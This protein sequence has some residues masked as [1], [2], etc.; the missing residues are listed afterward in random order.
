MPSPCRRISVSS[1]S[2]LP[3]LQRLLPLPPCLLKLS[4]SMVAQPV[5]IRLW[6][7]HRDLFLAGGLTAIAVLGL[8]LRTAEHVEPHLVAGAPKSRA[9]SH[10]RLTE[11][12]AEHQGQS[13]DL[14]ETT[15]GTRTS[16]VQDVASK[17]CDGSASARSAL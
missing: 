11:M 14:Q 5:L 17:T 8:H 9:T 4:F 16:L 12:R 2:P 10:A 15:H 3:P 7:T 13:L 1:I 6:L